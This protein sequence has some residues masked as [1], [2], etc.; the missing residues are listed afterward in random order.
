MF[1]SMFP[2]STPQT[3]KPMFHTMPGNDPNLTQ[4]MPMTGEGGGGWSGVL[5]NL[6][7]NPTIL[8]MM[9]GM[10]QA[11]VSENPMGAMGQVAQQHL[12]SEQMRKAFEQQQKE[13]KEFRTSLI[14]AMSGRG[15]SNDTTS[16]AP[17]K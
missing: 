8:S 7:S 14:A 16:S 5:T 11:M 4:M 6:M 13:D 10:G 1:N 9:S 3:F 12:Q 2:T 17:T 15:A